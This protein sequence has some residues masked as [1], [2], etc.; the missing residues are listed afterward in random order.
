MAVRLD[1]E[2]VSPSVEELH[3]EAHGALPDAITG[4][5]KGKGSHSVH[6]LGC[7]PRSAVILADESYPTDSHL[8]VDEEQLAADHLP[9]SETLAGEPP[10]VL[11][12]DGRWRRCA[13][14][15]LRD[16]AGSRLPLA[17]VLTAPVRGVILDHQH[18]HV[19]AAGARPLG[20]SLNHRVPGPWCASRADEVIRSFSPPARLGVGRDFG[21]GHRPDVQDGHRLRG[22][23]P[24]RGGGRRRPGRRSG[25]RR[26]DRAGG[27]GRLHILLMSASGQKFSALSGILTR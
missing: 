8:P 15:S 17:A 11:D 21:L 1:R 4:Q 23:S 7:L 14:G 20:A 18:P 3:L 16:G 24:R 22:G 25:H 19:R 9:R 2:A 5:P 12:L 10:V 13:G 27:L 6:R 26:G